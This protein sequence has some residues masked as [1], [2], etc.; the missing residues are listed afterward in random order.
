M[1]NALIITTVSGFL[2]KFEA[3]NVRLLQ[4]Q[5]YTVH[6]AANMTEPQYLFDPKQLDELGVIAH[7]IDIA[8]SPF[9]I[10][11]NLSAL[12]AVARLIDTCHIDLI[13]CHTPVGSLIGRLAPLLSKRKPSV[14]YT[15][16]GFHFYNGASRVHNLVYNSAERFLAHFTDSLILINTE[17][18]QAAQQFHLRPNG[19]T[20]LIPSIGLDL[21]H[22]H[23]AT[24]Q[25]K[26]EYRKKHGIPDNVFLI[27]SVGELNEN[28]NQ[29]VIL[30]VL[31]QLLSES[32]DPDSI[33]YGICG[34]GFYHNKLEEQIRLTGLEHHVTLFGYCLDVRE[35]IAMADVVVF[36]SRRE[37][38]GMA[39]LE[40]LSMGIPVVASDNRGTREYMQPGI[41]GFICGCDDVNAY[42]Q[43]IT[44][45]LKM[46]HD[47]R[48]SM[49]IAAR[50]SVER[51]DKSAT[52]P[53]MQEVYADI[54]RKAGR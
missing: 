2:L 6:Y 5:G 37:G 36:P 17:D 51:F 31:Q 16:H 21:A 22:F 47:E 46:S 39:A 26:A 53:I 32:A 25:E 14:I 29:L 27:L 23:P 33:H 15:A 34:E 4:K 19:K 50:A 7:H 24:P 44:Q 28:K 30:K 40:A 13:H 52:S 8:R 18:Y 43:G 54:S 1:K 41:N 9:M 11:Y 12:Q 48:R 49:G 3:E 42:V 35:Y 38:L 10:G 20:Y 45:I